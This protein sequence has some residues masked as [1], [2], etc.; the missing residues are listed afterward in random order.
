MIDLK[1]DTLD[2]KPKV[3]HIAVLSVCTLVLLALLL[4]FG[5]SGRPAGAAWSC[6]CIFWG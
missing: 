5:G 2:R 3:Y 1:L 6:A 4:V